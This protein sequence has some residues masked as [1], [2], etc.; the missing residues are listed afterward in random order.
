MKTAILSIL[1]FG[2]S[3]FIEVYRTI[4]CIGTAKLI[5]IKYIKEFRK[6]YND[7]IGIYTTDN[8]SYTICNNYIEFVKQLK[9]KK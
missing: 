1:L 9:R 7:H 5:N 2:D 4:P 3:Q 6:V 8:H